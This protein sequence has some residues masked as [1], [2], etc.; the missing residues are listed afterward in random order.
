MPQE[1]AAGTRKEKYAHM[2]KVEEAAQRDKTTVNTCMVLLRQQK[3][4]TLAVTACGAVN[5]LRQA[6]LRK[7]YPVKSLRFPLTLA[8]TLLNDALFSRRSH[9]AL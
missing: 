1:A 2:L 4:E 3:E 6:L 8:K 9:H 7:S 5:V